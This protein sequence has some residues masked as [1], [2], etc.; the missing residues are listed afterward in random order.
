MSPGHKIDR[1]VIEAAG[2]QLQAVVAPLAGYDHL[3]IE[4][5]KKA[6]I[7]VGNVPGVFDKGVAEHTITL[8]LMALYR[9]Q[10]H[11]RQV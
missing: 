11:V 1:A 6:G 4:D 7:R 5:I 2:P 8:I 3:N 9:V 10:E